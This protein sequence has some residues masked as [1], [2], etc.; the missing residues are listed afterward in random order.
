MLRMNNSASLVRSL[1]LTA[2]IL[3]CLQ[4]SFDAVADESVTFVIGDR[5]TPEGGDWKSSESPLQSPF[6]ID[7]D[8]L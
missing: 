4:S 8:S 1:V 6:G 7:L 3:S 2:A 5:M